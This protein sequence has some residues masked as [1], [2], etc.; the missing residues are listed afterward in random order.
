[1][2]CFSGFELY[3]RWVPLDSLEVFETARQQTDYTLRSV[4]LF[5][6]TTH[7]YLGICI[8]CWFEHYFA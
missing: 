6:L 7:L 1:M 3:S 5:T 8:F 2:L 4:N